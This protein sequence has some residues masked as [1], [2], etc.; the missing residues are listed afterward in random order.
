[1]RIRHI[2]QAAALAIA[3][4][5]AT[6]IPVSASPWAEVGDNQLRSDIQL[7]AAAGVVNDVTTHWP[8]PWRSILSN[9]GNA[10]LASQPAGVRL[11]ADRVLARARRETA[12]GAH[13]GA[14][15]HL[16]QRQDQPYRAGARL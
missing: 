3:G 12:P 13:G 16:R 8:L 2:F 10:S 4:F 14:Q 15:R 6:A 1:M 7:L 11:A 5:I 9:L